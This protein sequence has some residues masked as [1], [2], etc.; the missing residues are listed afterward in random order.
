[1][2]VAELALEAGLPAGILNVVHG[3]KQVV[4]AILNNPAIKAV[5][6]VGSCWRSD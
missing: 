5:S 6:F 2:R 4:D 1:V 3:D